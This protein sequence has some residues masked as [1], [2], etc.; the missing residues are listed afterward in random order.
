MKSLFLILSFVLLIIG[1]A[2]A[3]SV[4][5][6]FVEP[7]ITYERGTGDVD[8]PS[9]TN[10]SSTDVDGFVVGARLGFHVFDIVFMGLDG[11][12]AMPQFKHSSEVL[13]LWA[14]GRSSN[15]DATRSSSLG[16]LYL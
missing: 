8:F 13:E 5:G 7:M 14:C 12:Y 15:A 16:Q 9:P 3:A 4:G 1:S 6:V 2:Q 10:S 11:R